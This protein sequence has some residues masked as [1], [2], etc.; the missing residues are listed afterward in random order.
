MI[1]NVTWLILKL[2]IAG[3]FGLQ[4]LEND[5]I[6]CLNEFQV[7]KAAMSWIAHAT[8]FRA[9]HVPRILETIRF[10]NMSEGMP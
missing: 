5:G 7:F 10:S 1:A 6:V 2:L 4:I 9:I 3:R 8:P